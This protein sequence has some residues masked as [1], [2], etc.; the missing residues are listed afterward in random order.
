[1]EYRAKRKQ[2]GTKTELNSKNQPKRHGLAQWRRSAIILA[3]EGQLLCA[4]ACPEEPRHHSR[5]KTLDFLRRRGTIKKSRDTMTS[6]SAKKLKFDLI[7][8]ILAEDYK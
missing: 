4:V 7:R 3:K 1:M 2:S 8:S 6:A 5:K